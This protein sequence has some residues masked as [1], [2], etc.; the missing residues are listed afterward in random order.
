ME[1]LQG[2]YGEP[3]NSELQRILNKVAGVKEGKEGDPGPP[4]QPGPAG[5]DAPTDYAYSDAEIDTLN[6]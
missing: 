1:K 2:R 6:F 5:A 4:G 3:L